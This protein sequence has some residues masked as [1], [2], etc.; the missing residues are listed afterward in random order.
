MKITGKNIRDSLL[1]LMILAALLFA[2]SLL[3]RPKNNGTAYGF[4]EERAYG[5]LG[6]PANTMDVYVLGDSLA[7]C[8]ISPLEIWKQ[9]GI[10]VYVSSTPN[11]KLYQSEEML[12]MLLSH[13]QMPKMVILESNMVYADVE[14]M[15]VISH[16]L[17][18]AVPAARYHDRWKSLQRQDWLLNV[19]YTDREPEKGFY[20]NTEVKA[21]RE[22][23]LAEYM[24]YTEKVKAIPG[25][26]RMYLNRIAELC[27]ES[28]IQLVLMNTPS[29]KDWS[30][31]KH[32]GI[33]QIALEL[34]TA[35]VDMN[36]M[37]D[38]IPI[39]W[40]Q[41]TRDKGEHLNLTG[42]EKVSQ[43]LAQYLV[44]TDLFFDKRN[45]PEYAL[46]HS[47]AAAADAAIPNS[48]NP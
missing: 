38:E 7:E 33:E 9:T 17:E 45:D 48:S 27:R 46:W 4:Q 43:W 26:N 13:H 15:D 20:R 10:T 32:N 11:Q 19:H 29:V 28:G 23:R 47:D 36:L 41:D 5:F 3:F 40:A 42:A 16:W 2:A 8:A 44:E 39:D 14:P 21:T 37:P 24:A 22:A 34:N 18:M 31:R 35:Y 1:F 30:Y 6:E 12:K 25:E